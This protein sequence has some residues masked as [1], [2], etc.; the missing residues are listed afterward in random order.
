MKLPLD[1]TIA[2]EKIANY[3]LVHQSRGDK[4]QFLAA[5]GYVPDNAEKL[6]ADLRHQILPL[7]ANLVEQNQFGDYFEICGALSGPNGVVLRVR[8]IWMTD[9]LSGRTKF[10]TLL[11]DKTIK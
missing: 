1:T 6:L 3:L 5:A 11:P 7:D 2:R 8:T 9:R 4:S 10:V